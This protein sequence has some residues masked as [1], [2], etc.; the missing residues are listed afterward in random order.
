[1]SARG[2]DSSGKEPYRL[3]HAGLAHL[4]G[5]GE[6][7]G[8]ARQ[9]V[10]AR[11]RVLGG[12]HLHVVLVL[13][14]DDRNEAKGAGVHVALGRLAGVGEAVPRVEAHQEVTEAVVAV[15]RVVVGEE[16]RCV[17]LALVDERARHGVVREE[18][19]EETL[20]VVARRDE[21]RAAK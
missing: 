7:L 11:R 8:D 12:D 19:P 13:A 16:G 18:A 2:V 17:F 4:D 6:V 21:A 5:D 3:L 10:R 9:R 20:V 1:M 15:Q 14:V